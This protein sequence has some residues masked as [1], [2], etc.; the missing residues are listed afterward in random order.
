MILFYFPPSSAR[1]VVR[2]DSVRG[3][4]LFSFSVCVYVLLVLLVFL[5]SRVTCAHV[6]IITMCA[7]IVGQ[8]GHTWSDVAF[9]TTVDGDSHL[10]VAVLIIPLSALVAF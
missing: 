10:Y 2:A 4:C 6:C 8:C 5:V 9:S 7:D 1:A 3:A